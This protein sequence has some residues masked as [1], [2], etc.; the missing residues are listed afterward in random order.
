MKPPQSRP[1]ADFSA[2]RPLLVVTAV[3]APLIAAAILAQFRNDIT[4]ANAALGLVVLVVAAASTGVRAAGIVAALSSAVWFD[5][6]LTEPYHRFVITDSADI[7]TTLLLLVVGAAVSE[8]AL[9][10]RRQQ[11]GAS[12]RQG[13]LSGVLSTA[14]KVAAGGSPAPLVIEHVAQQLVDVLGIDA[15]GFDPEAGSANPQLNPDGTVTRGA[16]SIDVDRNGLPTDSEIDLPVQSGGVNHGRFLLTAASR[17]IRP[18]LEQR[19][20]AIALADQ[21]GAALATADSGRAP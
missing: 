5:F 10:G 18:T 16:R 14:A 4:N 7:E 15:C 2:K 12:R 6:F 17:V 13:Y 9:W 1:P 21:V 8:V 20:V 11:G 3:L 19:Q